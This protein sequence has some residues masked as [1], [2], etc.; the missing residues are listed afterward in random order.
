MHNF[1]YFNSNE[2]KFVREMKKTYFGIARDI[3]SLKK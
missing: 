2:E 1:I 3:E